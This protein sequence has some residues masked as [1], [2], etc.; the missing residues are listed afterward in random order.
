VIKQ[1]SVACAVVLLAAASTHAK[2]LK[3]KDPVSATKE[4]YAALEKDF[5]KANDDLPMSARLQALE[6]LD[7]KEAH[8]EVGRLDGNI[9]VNGQD[10]KISNVQITSRAVENAKDR[11][12]V[13]VRFKNF[14]RQEELHFFWEKSK[15][16][17][18]VDDLRTLD[19]DGGSTLSLMYKYGWDGPEALEKK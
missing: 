18:V 8:G 15:S 2:T 7:Q 4:L 1:A 19:K 10:A 3:V 5:D 9:Y 17:W 11:M 6:A 13:V 12:I 14:D 16:G